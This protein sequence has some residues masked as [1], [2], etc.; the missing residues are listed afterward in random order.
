KAK[1][2]FAL[3]FYGHDKDPKQAAFYNQIKDIEKVVLDYLIANK[4]SLHNEKQDAIPDDSVK[5]PFKS[6]LTPRKGKSRLDGSEREYENLYVNIPKTKRDYRIW[7]EE[8]CVGPEEIYE[9]SRMRCII[10]PVFWIQSGE[11]RLSWTLS[12]A[13]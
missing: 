13:D 10:Y 6:V 4:T 2:K 8:E 12:Q 11:V 7:K 5:F 9:Q 3:N 1:L